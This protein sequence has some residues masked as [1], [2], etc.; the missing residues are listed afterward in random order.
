MD[1]GGNLREIRKANG[2]TQKQI[3]D[4]LGVTSQAVCRWE[5]NRTEPDMYTV[6]KLAL[7][8]GCTTDDLTGHETAPLSPEERELVSLYRKMPEDAKRIILMVMKANP[9]AKHEEP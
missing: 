5:N 8:L 7:I 1:F 3:A 6:A 4:R 9:E 2:L